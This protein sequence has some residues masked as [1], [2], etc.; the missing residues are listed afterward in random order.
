VIPLT[1]GADAY[2]WALILTRRNRADVAAANAR[3]V[4]TTLA[5]P[6]ATRLTVDDTRRGGHQISKEAEKWLHD[7]LAAHH[8]TAHPPSGPWTRSRPV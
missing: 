2:E 6:G 7:A 5:G 3:I 8:A 4:Y 1:N